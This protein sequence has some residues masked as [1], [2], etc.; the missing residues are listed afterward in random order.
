MAG[1]PANNAVFEACHG[2]AMKTVAQPFCSHD[3][4]TRLGTQMDKGSVPT[5]LLLWKV[6]N[7]LEKLVIEPIDSMLGQR[8]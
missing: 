4:V 1:L 8:S 7:F 3:S 5:V 6:A 2:S